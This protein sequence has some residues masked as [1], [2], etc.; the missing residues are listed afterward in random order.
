MLKKTTL[1]FSLTFALVLTTQLQAANINLSTVPQ[2]ENIVEEQIQEEPKFKKVN[3]LNLVESPQKFL[4]KNIKM[5]AKFDKFAT[6][7]L[8]YPP[9]NRDTK[10]YISFLIK[11]ENVRG[12]DILLAESKYPEI[13]EGKIDKRAFSMIVYNSIGAEFDTPT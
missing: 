13:S 3:P 9:T 1:I 4:N 12:G 7:G 8:D 2:K 5:L 10:T 6:I 11:R